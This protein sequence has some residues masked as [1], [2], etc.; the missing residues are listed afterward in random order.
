M[1]EELKIWISKIAL[2]SDQISFKHL[3]EYF[4]LKLYDYGFYLIGNSYH[5]EEAVS[6]VFIS[7]WENRKRLTQIKNLQAYLYRSVKN[8]S[9]TYFRDKSNHTFLSIHDYDIE[10]RYENINPLDGMISQE[11][12]EIFDQ[13]IQGLPP[14][15]RLVFSMI[16][17]DGMKYHE[18]AELFE[19]SQKGVE[20]HMIKALKHI[21]TELKNYLGTNNSLHK[22]S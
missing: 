8:K 10:E 11:M 14:K 16:K 21:R 1:K 20:M 4:Y 3:F 19:I 18:V 2:D 7:L 13:A 15:C 12:I 17:E 5:T 22:L 9:I 6:S